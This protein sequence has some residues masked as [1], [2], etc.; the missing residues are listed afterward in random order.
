MAS[1]L[2]S[3]LYY[4]ENS[5]RINEQRKARRNSSVRGRMLAIC[6]NARQRAKSKDW[7]FNLTLDYLC[8]LW[9]IQEGKCAISGLPMSL[10]KEDKRWSSNMVS[11]DRIDSSLGYT[12]DNVWLVCT[13]VNFAKGT[14]S[15]EDFVEMCRHV[16]ENS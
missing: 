15:Y 7:G 16:V 12:K 4:L 14:Q 13:R 9:E 1:P 2:E 11:L 6:G 10:Q 3:K 5:E 8:G